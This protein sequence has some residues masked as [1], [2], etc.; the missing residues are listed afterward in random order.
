MN[1][2]F[3]A[4]Y[5]GHT[6]EQLKEAVETHKARLLDIRMVRR[7][8]QPE[9]NEEKL[10]VALGWRYVPVPTLGN[11]NYNNGRPID[12]LHPKVGCDIVEQL[13]R[14]NS[15]I[16]LCGCRDYSSCYRAVVSR[17]LRGRDI[18]T[19]ELEWPELPGRRAL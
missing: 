14:A 12:I 5:S 6:I 15:L 16:L 19:Q 1:K 18:Q 17:L 2:V 8:R 9:W 4:G 13:L 3:S 11:I 10:I 7:S